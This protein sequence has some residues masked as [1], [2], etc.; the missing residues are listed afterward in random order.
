[1]IPSQLKAEH[2]A[3]YPPQARSVATRN[4]VLLQQLPII[5]VPIFLRELIVYDWKFPAERR[6]LDG[7]LSYLSGQ[8]KTHLD[9][10]FSGFAQLSLS[11]NLEKLDWVN[12][13]SIFS[14]QLTAHLWATHQMDRFRAAAD[15]YQKSWRAAVPEAQPAM[16]R[17]GVVII[18]Q[19]VSATQYPLFRKLRPHGVFFTQ[20]KPDGGL[21]TL[22]DG[23]VARASAYPE[24]YGHWY[25][26]GGQS[27][28]ITSSSIACISYSALEPTRKAL[29]G[30]MQ[31]IIQSGSGGPEA[32]RTALAQ[33]QPSELGMPADGDAAILSRFAI[34]LLTEGSGT[35][36]FSTTFAQWGAREALRR[37]QPSTLM[38]RYAPRQRQLPM[39]ELLSTA[40]TTQELDPEGSLIDA[41][42]GAY[43]T[44]INQQRLTGAD[45]SAFIAWFEEHNQA[46]AIGPSLPRGTTSN[47]TTTLG[48]ILKWAIPSAGKTASHG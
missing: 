40:H 29:I 7:Q 2:F 12:A 11:P 23:V 4:L 31:K 43:Y 35:Q 17:L 21:Q 27:A 6:D 41:D 28:S 22:L 10:I 25:I 16:P 5:F 47:V 3:S 34:S 1:M 9:Q 42:M 18:G 15:A 19:G 30:H 32:L 14:E 33:M 38:V 26:D 45:Q 39:N 46:V 13:P 24:A 36:I 8:S 37:A 20:I 44:W 48:Q